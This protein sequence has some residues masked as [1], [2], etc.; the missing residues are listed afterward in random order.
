[1]IYK[2]KEGEI[3]LSKLTRLYPAAVIEL[4]GDKAE[5]SL[6]WT[7]INGDKVKVLNYILVF[8][9]TPHAQEE[10]IKTTL[11]FSSKDELIQ[12]MQKVSE[13]LNG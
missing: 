7:D 10:K 13:F 1:M 11:K 6:E 9:L 5:M 2:T 4:G 3:D 8:D 12:E